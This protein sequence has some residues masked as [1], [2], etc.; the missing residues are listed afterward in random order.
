VWL[1]P[2]AAATYRTPGG[3]SGTA[4]WPQKL[5][6]MHTALPSLRS[7]TAWLSL[8]AAPVCLTPAGAPGMAV[9][10][11]LFPPQDTTLPSSQTSSVP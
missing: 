4:H 5:L 11:A 6:P 1:T 3:R 7:S 9:G 10:T 8:V 2:A